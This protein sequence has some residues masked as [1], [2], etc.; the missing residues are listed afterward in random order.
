MKKKTLTI[1]IGVV[2]ILAVV[3][4]L[5]LKT[6][7][8]E[9]MFDKNGNLKEQYAVEMQKEWCS[10]NKDRDFSKEQCSDD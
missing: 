3:F 9:G 1:L 8:T 6:T 4:S 10:H 7:E 2:A 5:T